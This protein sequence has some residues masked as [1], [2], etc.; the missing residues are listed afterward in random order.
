[1]KKIPPKRL[2]HLLRWDFLHVLY[3][4]KTTKNQFNARFNARIEC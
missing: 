3:V 4:T 2:M 1:M